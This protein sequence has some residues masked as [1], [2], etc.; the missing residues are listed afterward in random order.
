MWR[1]NGRT[2]EDVISDAVRNDFEERNMDLKSVAQCWERRES[3]SLISKNAERKRMGKRLNHRLTINFGEQSFEGIRLSAAWG[4]ICR[5]NFVSGEFP[6]ATRTKSNRVFRGPGVPLKLRS[7][8]RESALPVVGLGNVLRVFP[9][10]G[11]SLKLIWRRWGRRRCHLL[12]I[13]GLCEL[14]FMSP[15]FLSLELEK[16]YHFLWDLNV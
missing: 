15:L 12:L 6:K 8:V 1:E 2:T 11:G 14:R 4:L 9:S 3:V 10:P 5:H 16:L 13:D 7:T